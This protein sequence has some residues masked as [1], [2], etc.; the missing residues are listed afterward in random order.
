MSVLGICGFTFIA[1]V[2]AYHFYGRVLDNL[3]QVAPERETPAV[4]KN[5]G[6]DYVPA[7]H[8][9]ILFGHHFSSIAGAGPILGPVIA[10][11]LWGWGPAL[12]W[13]VLGSI[14]LGGVHDFSSLML[15]LRYQGNSVGDVTASV[16]GRRSQIV[17]SLFLWITLVL[18]VAVFAAITARTLVAEPHI[19]IPT[20]GLIL[21]AVIFGFLVYR[22]GLNQAVATI[23]SLLLIIGL[24]VL[25]E[26]VPVTIPGEAGVPVWIVILL[27]YAGI[28]SVV[29]VHFLLQ[30]R[31]YLSAYILFVGM[32]VGYLGVLS[33]R[34]TFQAPFFLGYSSSQGNLWPMLMVTV[35]CGAISGFHA[36]VSSGTSSK[37]IRSEKDGRKVTYGAMLTEGALALLALICVA[38]GLTWN[39]LD[40][41]ISYSQLMKSGEPIR[42]FGLGYGQVVARIIGAK[43][44]SF[45]AMVM[46][47]G[48][49]LT[50]LDTATRITRYLTEELF[51][52]TWRVAILRQRYVATLLVLACSAYLAF[53]NWQK[54][55][56]VF[57]ASNQLVAAIVLLVCACYLTLTGRNWTL[58]LV[59]SVLM[60]LTTI[61]ALVT[62]ASQFYQKKGY[63]LGNVAVGLV[64]LAVFVMEEAVRLILF[65]KRNHLTRTGK[66]N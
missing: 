29:P 11:V 5:D 31:D 60:F 24:F 54:L 9:T 56:P 15:S 10:G 42:T 8:W 58:I 16:L 14:F 23:I 57:G 3:W 2:L 55:W 17:F 33:L 59:P 53:G 12:A 1:F 48:F 50:T 46:I 43:A 35:A 63:L 30:P 61:W 34:P 19:V 22:G 32:A 44:G 6:V 47:N 62:Q 38:A 39:G 20:F 49:V 64:L 65:R 40:T 26:H 21:V 28:A 66:E 7:R 18:I 27:V 45:L 37:Q 36:L 51:G 52:R 25:G 41:A 13:I 4:E